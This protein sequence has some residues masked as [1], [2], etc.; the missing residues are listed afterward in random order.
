[1]NSFINDG[2]WD[3][4]SGDG[5]NKFITN[6]FNA[7]ASQYIKFV[8]VQLN[9]EQDATF[10]ADNQEVGTTNYNLQLQKT[11]LNNRLIFKVTG[12][13]SADRSSTSSEWRSTIENAYV[14]YLLTPDGKIKLRGFSEDGLEILNGDGGRNS[15]AGIVFTKE[16]KK[17]LFRKR[18]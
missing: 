12:G 8:D 11:F 3:S 2:Q 13:A 6:Q 10:G 5:I 1:M 14:E 7:L 16:Y 4:A 18:K 17:G 15:G 9:V